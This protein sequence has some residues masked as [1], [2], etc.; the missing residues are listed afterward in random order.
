VHAPI[1]LLGGTFDP[2][3]LGHLHLA[4]S[5][6]HALQMQ[7]VHLLP[8]ATPNLRD[9]P[10]ADAQQRL[11]MVELAL[12]NHP[13]LLVDAREILLGNGISY[14]INTLMA[15][16]AELG[17]T[18]LCFI[19]SIDQLAQLDQ[20]YEW[21]RILEFAHLVVSTRSGVISEPSLTVKN[22]VKQHQVDDV[23]LLQQHPS[24]HIFFLSIIPL[25][26][27]ATRIR[28]GIQRQEKDVYSCLPKKVWEYIGETGLY[29]RENKC[30]QNN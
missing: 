16:R 17:D 9:A 26:I 18:P 2:I 1:G 13:H 14:T 28:Q 6:Y 4:L 20:W 19:M 22:W 23:H 30:K 5:V 11:S 7:A 29:N 25:A 8:C 15:I 21:R 3:H 24:G 27:S 10:I 12:E